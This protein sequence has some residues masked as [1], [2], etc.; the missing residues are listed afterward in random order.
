MMDDGKLGMSAGGWMQS[1][2]QEYNTHKKAEL[3]TILLA[4][5]SIR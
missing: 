2:I 3:L 4:Q 5:A 1:S